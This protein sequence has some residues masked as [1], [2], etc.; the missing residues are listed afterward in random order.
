MLTKKQTV[1]KS[2]FYLR[3]RNFKGKFNEIFWI[4]VIGLKLKLS[5]HGG[6]RFG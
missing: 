6:V 3:F 5:F 1:I 4:N 2:Y